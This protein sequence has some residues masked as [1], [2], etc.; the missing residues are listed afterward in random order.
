MIMKLLLGVTAVSC[1][2]SDWMHRGKHRYLEVIPDNYLIGCI[3]EHTLIVQ[4]LK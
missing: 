4:F 3:Y 2:F 1:I